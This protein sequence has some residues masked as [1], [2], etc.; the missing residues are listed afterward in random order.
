MSRRRSRVVGPLLGVMVLTLGVWAGVYYARS[1][2]T[3]VANTLPKTVASA[4]KSGES[5]KNVSTFAE[6]S[7]VPLAATTEPVGVIEPVG[8]VATTEPTT[9][10]VVVSPTTAPVAE[11]A[12]PVVLSSGASAALVEG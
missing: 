6:K 5:P 8:A 2:S 12:R 10:E 7:A 3:K 1:H 11:R 4:Q 9:R